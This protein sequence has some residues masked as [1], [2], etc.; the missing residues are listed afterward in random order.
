[1]VTRPIPCFILAWRRAGQPTGRPSLRSEILLSYFF[2]FFAT[3]FF[4]I[5]NLLPCEL[6]PIA[7]GQTRAGCLA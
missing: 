2:F 6:S 4:F 1:M 7:P 3:G 5:W